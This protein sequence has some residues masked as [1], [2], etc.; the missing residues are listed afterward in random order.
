MCKNISS[1]NIRAW[2]E[3]D[4]SLKVVLWARS[5]DSG[6]IVG[7][8]PCDLFYDMLVT[9]AVEF[10][11]KEL[12]LGQ[13]GVNT[14]QAF[15]S[16]F[17]EL[18]GDLDFCDADV[19]VD[20]SRHVSKSIGCS[21]N[22]VM[23]AI[24]RIDWCDRLNVDHCAYISESVMD[25]YSKCDRE[26]DNGLELL[27]V[28]M[29]EPRYMGVE[30]GPNVRESFNARCSEE[31]SIY[32]EGDEDAYDT[33][34][35][36]A[37]IDVGCTAKEIDY[38]LSRTYEYVLDGDKAEVSTPEVT[39]DVKS[40]P[41]ADWLS[42]IKSK[43]DV[44]NVAKAFY[45]LCIGKDAKIDGEHYGPGVELLKKMKKHLK[46]DGLRIRDWV[47]NIHLETN[48]PET[49]IRGI[50]GGPDYKYKSKGYGE[51]VEIQKPTEV[52][53]EKVVTEEDFVAKEKRCD[54]Y[55][56][57]YVKEAEKVVERATKKKKGVIRT[58]TE[59]WD[60]ARTEFLC[61]NLAR[62]PKIWVFFD[63]IERGRLS[64][65]KKHYIVDVAYRHSE[66][67]D[68]GREYADGASF[69][70]LNGPMRRYM[71]NNKD[72]EVH[73]WELRDIDID[74]CFP[75]ILYQIGQK[76]GM[77]LNAMKDYVD[78]RDEVLTEAMKLYKCKRKV[79]KQMFLIEMHG[80]FYW[81][82]MIEE[83]GY[84]R[85]DLESIKFPFMDKFKGDVRKAYEQLRYKDEFKSVY[86]GI[87]A[88]KTKS[89]KR[90]TFISYI[91]QDVEAKVISLCNTACTEWGYKVSS[92][93][94]DG[95]MVRWDHDSSKRTHST[96]DEFLR[97][98]EKYVSDHSDFKLGFSNKTLDLECTDMKR[99]EPNDN[100]EDK[101]G[102]Y[103]RKIGLEDMPVVKTANGPR[104]VMLP[105]TDSKRVTCVTAGMYLGKSTTSKNYLKRVLEDPD[106]TAI[107]ISVRKQ[108]ARTIMGDLGD[109]GFSHYKDNLSLESK[110]RVVYQYE[111]IHK[112]LG[113]I[114]DGK[115]RYEYVVLDES[116]SIVKNIVSE[117][118][119]GNLK[120]SAKTLELILQMSKKVLCLDADNQYDKSVREY[121]ESIFDSTEIEHLWYTHQALKRKVVYTDSHT[122]MHNVM[123]DMSNNRNI[124]VCF[125]SCT[126]L[127]TW[128]DRDI[129][130]EYYTNENGDRVQAKLGI[131]FGV[132][133]FSSDTSSSE[134]KVFEN[135]ND[136]PKTGLFLAFTSKVLVGSDILIPFHRLYLEAN[137][138]RG[139]TARQ[140]LQMLGRGRVCTTGEIMVTMPRPKPTSMKQ[141]ELNYDTLYKTQFRDLES[142]REKREQYASTVLDS[143]QRKW[144]GSAIE[145]TPDPILMVY[146]HLQVECS[147]EFSVEFHRLVK[148][149]GYDVEFRYNKLDKNVEGY[150]AFEW[151]ESV[152]E[153]ADRRGITFSDALKDM[154]KLSIQDIV[155]YC[156]TVK[157]SGKDKTRSEQIVDDIAFA[158]KMFPE[159]YTELTA[160]DVKYAIQ[161]KGIVYL[162]HEVYSDDKS[163]FLRDLATMKY[164][165]IPEVAKLRGVYV[166]R[167][168][169]LLRLIGFKD[170]IMDRES[171]V[172]QTHISEMMGQY[173]KELKQMQDERGT[174]RCSSKKS[175]NVLR[176]ELRQVGLKLQS[177][178]IR[179]SK[180]DWSTTFTLSLNETLEYLVPKMRRNYE[181]KD[182]NVVDR[183]ND[184]LED[185]FRPV[186]QYYD[187]FHTP[188][189]NELPE[190]DSNKVLGKL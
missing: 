128:Y 67:R 167:L 184:V 179:H 136:L 89:N 147:K 37:A 79:A 153:L 180:T 34:C 178:V 176:S 190:V 82:T 124:M 141:K 145:W 62:D 38:V 137:G 104:P 78:R 90:G 91:C 129:A 10:H 170:G 66:A 86:E 80:G 168:D 132:R 160:K 18:H 143:Y 36:M 119:K 155:G 58:L 64:D 15:N 108:H 140:M 26:Y 139:P 73:G 185:T 27:R 174:I 24:N 16:V 32:E 70:S 28:A 84:S 150:D 149:K 46:P 154:Q 54:A 65:D 110:R 105:F 182:G 5:Y 106:A 59:Y 7:D 134:M 45:R 146:A 117:T 41:V 107:A 47:Y 69:Q 115:I 158:C 2:H 125:K 126:R 13:K 135:I 188:E 152:Q 120:K 165:S 21:I 161:N 57:K 17:A 96:M 111:S 93:V 164:A 181:V 87:L 171:V 40:D 61:K 49:T 157:N 53:V 1:K 169:R 118:N 163:I 56:E 31:S 29:Y 172:N 4:F 138:F 55:V 39:K 8:T 35:Q 52:G 63:V 113:D 133:T 162:A 122:W 112:L 123:D 48:I 175:I 183:V 12:A 75:V 44:P 30:F 3:V 100:N 127:Q 33:Y 173:S 9:D 101:F 189:D 103:T 85:K 19:F 159:H 166:K 74:N 50:L 116:H 95:F 114:L 102:K 20:F 71:C 22:E 88:D 42:T 148:N 121:I 130:N 23:Y 187:I 97:S 156:D 131:K 144:N 76:Y 77:E 186:N 14:R 177:K 51:M 98:V 94:F 72:A 11:D 142:Q 99:L 43:K 92:L 109:L 81:K 25:W 60:V 68:S 151:K 83:H 6:D